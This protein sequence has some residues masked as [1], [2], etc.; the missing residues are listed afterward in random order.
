MQKE[1]AIRLR[2]I[3]STST[4]EIPCSIFDIYFHQQLFGR[5]NEN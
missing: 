2:P 3:G 4:F 1:K 5:S